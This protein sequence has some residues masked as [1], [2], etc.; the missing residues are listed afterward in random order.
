MFTLASSQTS[1]KMR[2]ERTPKDVCGEAML[3]LYRIVFVLPRKS[4]RIGFLFKHKI[5]YDGKISVMEQN[6]ATPISKAGS[7]ILDRCCHE[8]ATRY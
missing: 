8:Q 7:H 3:T 1:F 6:C 4:Y 5:G 2:D